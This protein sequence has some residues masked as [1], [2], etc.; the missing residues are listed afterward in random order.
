MMRGPTPSR[1]PGFLNQA[2]YSGGEDTYSQQWVGWWI[3]FLPGQSWGTLMPG[4]GFVGHQLWWHALCLNV[5]GL[6]SSQVLLS[7]FPTGQS[8]E[9]YSAVG[10]PMT[11][12]PCLGGGIRSSS[13][14]KSL[15]KDLNQAHLHHIEFPGETETPS[16]FCKWAKLLV[17]IT[18]LVVQVRTRFAKA[19]VLVVVYTSPLFF[20]HNQFLNSQAPHLPLQSS[21]G[22]AEM[23]LPSHDSQCYNNF[24]CFFFLLPWWIALIHSSCFN[25]VSWNFFYKIIHL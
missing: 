6:C 14:S 8:W 5:A 11:C 15:L 22:Q 21:W 3:S 7:D 23:G 2:F 16:G 10:R 1:I 19:E 9:L 25:L 13:A 17:R 24:L 12:L 20:H 4:I 18:T